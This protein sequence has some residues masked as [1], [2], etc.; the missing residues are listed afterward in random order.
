MAV[1]RVKTKTKPKD[2]QYIEVLSVAAAK[3]LWSEKGSPETIDLR[4]LLKRYKGFGNIQGW[5]IATGT[6]DYDEIGIPYG[7]ENRVIMVKFWKGYG[8][9]KKEWSFP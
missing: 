5:A 2:P 3:A 9:S 8:K 1:A 4:N 7:P 6:T